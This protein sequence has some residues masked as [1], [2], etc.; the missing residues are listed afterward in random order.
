MSASSKPA[1]ANEGFFGASL[2]EADPEIA[3]VLRHADDILHAEPL[4]A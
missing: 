4:H 1:P 3:D 2:R